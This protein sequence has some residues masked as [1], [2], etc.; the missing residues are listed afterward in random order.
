MLNAYAAERGVDGVALRVASCYGPGRTTD[1]F[2]RLLVENALAGRPTRVRDPQARDRQHIH[3]NDVTAGVLAA[4]DIPV[5]QS[6]VYNIAPG[7]VASSAEV[8]EAVGQAIEGVKLEQDPDAPSWNS[9]PLGPLSIDRARA[10]A[11]L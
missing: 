11:G 3:V 8:A 1:C 6:R 5:L 7:A 10:R 9:F 2:V 4:L